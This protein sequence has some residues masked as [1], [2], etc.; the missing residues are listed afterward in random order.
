MATTE[1]NDVMN[2]ITPMLLRFFMTMYQTES[3]GILI[4]TERMQVIDIS[5]HSIVY[6]MEK[7]IVEFLRKYE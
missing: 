5:K 3:T 2:L 6:S 7:I 4:I 1:K